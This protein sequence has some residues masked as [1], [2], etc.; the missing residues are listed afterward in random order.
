[1]NWP[2]RLMRRFNPSWQTNN[3]GNELVFMERLNEFD[4]PDQP[5]EPKNVSHGSPKQPRVDHVRF[6]L[7]KRL[8]IWEKARGS[9]AI[10]CESL[11]KLPA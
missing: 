1:M 9:S 4:D 3:R 5:N 6:W 7:M 11:A 2:T 8:R 10:L